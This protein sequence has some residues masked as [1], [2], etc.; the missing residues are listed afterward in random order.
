MFSKMK[1]VFENGVAA[2]GT[3][4]NSDVPQAGGE[5]P[6]SRDPEQPTKAPLFDTTGTY[7]LS[8]DEQ[9]EARLL[10]YF[11]FQGNDGF[12]RLHEIEAKCSSPDMRVVFELTTLFK[13][14]ARLG[15]GKRTTFLQAMEYYLRRNPERTSQFLVLIGLLGSCKDY[16]VFANSQ[17]TNLSDATV[18][19]YLA[20]MT[21]SFGSNFEGI[22]D[23]KAFTELKNL[24]G[25]FFK[26]MPI[27]KGATK[28]SFYNKMV[29]LYYE[30]KFGR[31]LAK[32]KK[33]FTF[34]CMEFRK[35]VTANRKTSEQVMSKKGGLKEIDGLQDGV[36]FLNTLPAGTR[37]KHSG[38]T[39]KKVPRALERNLPQS[40]E[41]WRRALV[42]GDP[43]AKVNTAKGTVSAI[44][45]LDSYMDK[46]VNYILGGYGYTTTQMPEMT[47]EVEIAFKEILRNSRE[48]T[49]TLDMIPLIDL[50][51]S[52]LSNKAINLALILA[53]IFTMREDDHPLDGIWMPFSESAKIINMGHC[54]TPMEWLARFA[55]E[56]GMDKGLVGYS[57]NYELAINKLIRFSEQNRITVPDIISVTDMRMNEWRSSSGNNS[58]GYGYQSY[59]SEDDA[60]S[61]F[62][63]KTLKAI[64][65]YNR[66]MGFENIPNTFVVNCSCKIGLVPMTSKFKNGAYYSCGAKGTQ[67]SVLQ[68]V[69]AFS[70]LKYDEVEGSMCTPT[71]WT[72]MIKS[73]INFNEKLMKEYEIDLIGETLLLGEKWFE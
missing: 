19:F 59:S 5:Y 10:E 3:A 25:L 11:N 22:C 70:E 67:V 30:S 32:N 50:S 57:T 27:N 62:T 71:P 53:M 65:S 28:T 72:T 42:R 33:S 49:S 39:K 24:R 52:M 1:T 15:D 31:P 61:V 38:Y 13:R 63:V 69:K 51:C 16:R 68:V 48:I 2:F 44:S 46:Y 64:A 55:T 58:Y 47:P 23:S 18:K 21:E 17:D 60:N 56:V 26:W 73:L 40:L 14:A 54:S 7:F 9:L 35:F 43:S 66:R 36:T 4:V 29:N 20:F 37:A 41:E 45:V 6:V 34:A 8:P 12:P